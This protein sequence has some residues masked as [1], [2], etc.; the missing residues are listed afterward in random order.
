MSKWQSGILPSGVCGQ[1]CCSG[2]TGRCNL[3]ITKQRMHSILR[4]FLLS[5]CPAAIRRRLRPGSQLT[6][7]R[8]ATW[9]GLAQALLAGFILVVRLKNHFVLRAQQLGPHIAGSNETGQTIIA[10]IVLLDFLIHPLSLLL[11]Y[12][13][14]EGFI[15][16]AGGLI[17]GEIVPNLLV[18]LYFKTADSVSRSSARR[19]GA[20]AVPDIA[21]RLADGRIRIFSAGQKAGWNS[22]VTIGIGGQWFELESEAQAPLPRAFT[23][24]LRPASPGKVLR[25][26]QE[27]DAANLKAAAVRT[28]AADAEQS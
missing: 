16:F 22:S 3:S 21:E 25:G 8:S 1:F 12:L 17:T 28:S 5:F 27:Y 24:V 15:R 23:Y 18:S 11:L 9:G 2:I 13:A 10:G 4:D 7:L 6:V 26:Y 14:I 20:P 19:R